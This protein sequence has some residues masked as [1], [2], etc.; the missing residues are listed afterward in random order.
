M[1][2]FFSDP[3]WYDPGLA[4]T[5]PQDLDDFLA[6]WAAVPVRP[7]AQ[8]ASAQPPPAPLPPALPALAPQQQQQQ[9]H[10]HQQQ[11]LPPPQQ[12][13]GPPVAQGVP[14]AQPRWV[15]LA[16]HVPNATGT[17]YSYKA[18]PGVSNSPVCGL[19][20]GQ[21]VL[22]DGMVP[23]VFDQVKTKTLAQEKPAALDAMIV[24]MGGMPAAGNG[25][26]PPSETAKARWIIESEAPL[27]T[28]AP[29]PGVVSAGFVAGP[30]L[31]TEWLLGS[32][33]G[34]VLVVGP[35][36]EDEVVG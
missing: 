25:R 14:A 11:A 3:E 36:T 31:A 33:V 20:P 34:G 35:A 23:V 10:H 12:V 21:D 19:L 8:A 4:A 28:P 6:A 17:Y 7:L 24:A 22:G 27:S 18:Q 16:Q 30:P 15:W 32:V 5:W 9:Q 2:N 29:V 13:S 26:A 1:Y